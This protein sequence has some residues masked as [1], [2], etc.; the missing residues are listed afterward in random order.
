MARV[1]TEGRC[2]LCDEMAHVDG[3]G[4]LVSDRPFAYPY[5]RTPRHF[6]VHQGQPHRPRIARRLCVSQRY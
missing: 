3:L 1:P 5:A 6:W 4:P 2:V